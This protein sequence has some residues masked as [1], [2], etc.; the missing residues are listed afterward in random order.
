MPRLTPVHWKV[1]ECI[2]KLDGFVLARQEGDHRAYE[3]S[4]CLRPIIIPTY[5]SIDIEIIKTNMRTAVMSR[6]K[7]FQ[8]LKVCQKSS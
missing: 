5:K 2:F 3:K 8:Y 7:Y 6:E 1:L 4:G